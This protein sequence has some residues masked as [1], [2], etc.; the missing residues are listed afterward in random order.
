MINNM[1]QTINKVCRQAVTLHRVGVYLTLE[2]V[3]SAIKQE[4]DVEVDDVYIEQQVKSRLKFK[5][6]AF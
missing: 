6:K 5:L 2:Q 1:E 3:V 4:L